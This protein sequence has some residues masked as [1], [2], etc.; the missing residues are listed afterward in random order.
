[1]TRRRPARLDEFGHPRLGGIG[2][3]LEREIEQRTGFETRATVLGHV[4]RGGT[5]TAFDRVL[6]T[7]LGL[8]AID[9]AHAGP[10][11]DD[12]RAPLDPDRAGRRSPTRSP[13]SASSRRGVRALRRAVRLRPDGRSQCLHLT[14]SPGR[15]VRTMLRAV[16]AKSR[17]HSA[18]S[19]DGDRRP[20]PT[21]TGCA[22]TRSARCRWTRV[23]K[24]NSGHPGTPMALA[25]LAYVLYARVMRHNPR[26]PDVA[27]P[28]PVRPVLRPRVDA[29]VLDAVPDRLRLTPRA[30]SST[31]A[32]S[33]RRPPGHPEYGTC[34]GSR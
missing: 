6:A 8:A 19:G 21:S 5:P 33:A 20:P 7:R 18:R 27:G 15:G 14:P 16:A 13:R 11:G 1:M 34:P 28:R 9:A 23:Q 30:T 4:Q 22:S 24:A 31:S 12:D 3:A 25:P 29:P 32:S 26:N 2:H 10:V 17:S